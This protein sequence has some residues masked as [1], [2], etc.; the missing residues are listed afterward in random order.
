MSGEYRLNAIQ[1]FY[2]RGSQQTMPHPW[3]CGQLVLVG[4][5]LW[6]ALYKLNS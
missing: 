2:I 6:E 1:S 4:L 5:P 3:T